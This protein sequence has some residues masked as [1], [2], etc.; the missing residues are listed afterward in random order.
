MS[1]QPFG[2]IISY[3]CSVSIANL[4]AH[5]TSIAL[6]SIL[7]HLIPQ[8]GSVLR[9]GVAV[10]AAEYLTLGKDVLPR[11]RSPVT[12]LCPLSP[13]VGLHLQQLVQY[14]C[15]HQVLLLLVLLQNASVRQSVSCKE[16]AGLVVE[17]YHIVLSHQRCFRISILGNILHLEPL[18]QTRPLHFCGAAQT[19]ATDYY[20][21]AGAT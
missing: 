15:I 19:T 16:F 10:G 2:H 20:V 21:D 11:Y 18:R 5:Q 3:L 17:C 6:A 12:L 8:S 9:Q 7:P 1:K 14:R 13:L 4:A